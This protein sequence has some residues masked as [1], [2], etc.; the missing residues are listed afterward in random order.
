MRGAF[1]GFDALAEREFRLLFLGRVVS[2]AGSA[3][4]PVALAFAVL[5]LTGSATDLGLTLLAASVPQILFLLVGGVWADRLPRHAVMIGANLVSGAAQALVA[6]LLLTGKA[7]IWHLIVLQ[8]FRGTSSGFFFPASSGIVPQVVSSGRL[9]QANALLS[10]SLNTTTIGGAAI[11]GLLVAAAGPGWAIAVDATTFFGSSVFLGA[12][13]LPGD[14]RLSVKNFRDELREGWSEFS[15]RT[16]IWSIVAAF[17]F[18]NTA[19]VAGMQVL[20]PAVAKEKLGGAAAWGLILAAQSAGLVLGSFIVLRFRPS[21][22]LL[23]AQSGI[24]LLTPPLALLAVGAPT[25]AVAAGAFTA[26][27]GS[28]LFE[29]LWQTA[30]QENVPIE[31]LSRV[32]SYDAFGS[33]AFVPIGL[34]AAGPLADA[35]GVDATLWLTFALINVTTLAV[36]TVPDV[37][38]LRRRSAEDLAT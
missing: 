29:I 25:L 12:M 21:R 27:V 11:G 3:M 31:R 32:S 5:D 13:R 36:L 9:Q 24:F 28:D 20:G 1:A 8:A 16:W 34:A 17:A 14:A 37:R 38:R 10:L 22:P 7:E 18:I 2:L 35:I 26:G 33:L 15:S 4:A 19:S 23:V 6:V 30:L